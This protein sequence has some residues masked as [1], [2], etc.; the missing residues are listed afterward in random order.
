MQPKRIALAVREAADAKKA[1]DPVILDLKKLT[2]LCH[3][4]VII[5]GNSDRHVRAVCDHVLETLRT[6]KIRPFH[7]EGM[8]S[9][10]WVLIDY[11]SVIVHIFH[12]QLREFYA[13]ERLWGDAPR[14]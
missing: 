6:K 8:D 3:Y 2:S 10:Q 9:G 4:F 11:G 7:V 14:V 1:E 5:H 12:R 13:L